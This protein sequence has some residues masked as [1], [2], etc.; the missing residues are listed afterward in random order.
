MF[1]FKIGVG[2]CERPKNPCCNANIKKFELDVD[3]ACRKAGFTSFYGKDLNNLVK[4]P[5]QPFFDNPDGA[6]PDGLVLKVT[7]LGLNKS[8]ADGMHLCFQYIPSARTPARCGTPAGLCRG[9]D[10]TGSRLCNVALTS[11]DNNCCPVT[12]FIPAAPPSPPRP[13][14]ATP[15]TCTVCV[16]QAINVTLGAAVA[17][18]AGAVSKITADVCAY[19]RDGVDYY[20]LQDS[21]DPS[22]ACISNYNAAKAELNVGMK[23]CFLTTAAVAED[24][25]AS[26]YDSKGSLEWLVELIPDEAVCARVDARVTGCTSWPDVKPYDGGCAFTPE[27]PPPE[28]VTPTTIAP[29]PMP[30]RTFGAAALPAYSSWRYPRWFQIIIGPLDAEDGENCLSFNATATTATKMQVS[31]CNCRDPGQLV[32][33]SFGKSPYEDTKVGPLGFAVIQFT[34]AVDV[35]RTGATPGGC[36]QQPLGLTISEVRNDETDDLVLGPCVAPPQSNQGRRLQGGRVGRAAGMGGMGDGTAGGAVKAAWGAEDA[37]VELNGGAK[38]T[39]YLTYGDPALG[40]LRRTGLRRLTQAGGAGS[41]PALIFISKN[42]FT[43]PKYRVIMDSRGLLP[44]TIRACL[45]AVMPPEAG[46]ELVFQRCKYAPRPGFPA[47]R[48]FLAENQKWRLVRD[49]DARDAARSLLPV[50]STDTPFPYFTIKSS[51]TDSGGRELCPSPFNANQGSPSKVTTERGLCIYS[52]GAVGQP[53][54]LISSTTLDDVGKSV[55]C[56]PLTRDLLLRIYLAVDVTIKPGPD[57][58]NPD[59]IPVPDAIKKSVD[60]Y[61]KYVW[62]HLPQIIPSKT[63]ITNATRYIPSDPNVTLTLYGT[64]FPVLVVDGQ[65]LISGM[66]RVVLATNFVKSTAFNT[67]EDTAFCDIRPGRY[68]VLASPEMVIPPNGSWARWTKPSSEPSLGKPDDLFSQVVLDLARWITQGSSKWDEDL[69]QRGKLCTSNSTYQPFLEFLAAERPDLFEDVNSTSIQPL[70]SLATND[71]QAADNLIKSCDVYVV[72]HFDNMYSL[73]SPSLALNRYLTAGGKALLAV[74]NTLPADLSTNTSQIRIFESGIIVDRITEPPADFGIGGRRRA[75]ADPDNKCLDALF[76]PP[77]PPSPPPS[78]P[79]PPSPPVPGNSSLVVPKGA[80]TKKVTDDLDARFSNIDSFAA[81]ILDSSSTPPTDPDAQLDLMFKQQVLINSL[82]SIR[83]ACDKDAKTNPSDQNLRN[84]LDRVNQLLTSMK[85]YRDELQL[86]SEAVDL[87][88]DDRLTACSAVVFQESSKTVKQI[89]YLGNLL[90]ATNS[91]VTIVDWHVDAPNRPSAAVFMDSSVTIS[92]SFWQSIGSEFYDGDGGQAP[93]LIQANRTSITLQN[94]SFANYTS[95]PVSGFRVQL[96]ANN[97]SGNA[98]SDRNADARGGAVY[99]DSCEPGP[100]G[101][102]IEGGVLQYN[103]ARMGGALYIFEC[104]ATLLGVPVSGNT[105][106]YGGAVYAQHAGSTPHLTQLRMIDSRFE[107]NSAS[108]QGGALFTLATGVLV[109]NCTFVRQSAIYSAVGVVKEAS[110]DVIPQ[111]VPNYD[112]SWLDGPAFMRLTVTNSTFADN[113][114]V[115]S[116]GVLT[117]DDSESLFIGYGGVLMLTSCRVTGANVIS[118]AFGSNYAHGSGGAIMGSA[119]KML[120]QNSTFDRNIAVAHGGAVYSVHR[121]SAASTEAA[122]PPLR[123]VESV[124]TANSAQQ[125]DGGAVLALS[126]RVNITTCRFEDNAAPLGRGGGCAVDNNLHLIT[127]GGTFARNR[128]SEGGALMV[129][130]T[131]N[132]TISNLSLDANTASALGGGASITLCPCVDV[133][134]ATATNNTAGTGVTGSGGGIHLLQTTKLRADSPA[135]CHLPP[136]HSAWFVSVAA[137]GNT[138]AD[139]GGAFLIDGFG[140]DVLLTNMTVSGNTAASGWGGGIAIMPPRAGEKGLVVGT[141]YSNQVVIGSSDLSSNLAGSGGGAVAVLSADVA[142]SMQLLGSVLHNNRAAGDG[143]AVHV[144]GN[145]TATISQ[146]VLSGNVAQQGSGGALKALGC[147]L[148]DITNSTFAANAATELGGAAHVDACRMLSLQQIWVA[149]NTAASAGGLAITNPTTDS[150]T[151]ALVL[152]STFYGDVAASN[153]STAMG[154]GGAMVIRGRVAALVTDTRFDSNYADTQGGAVLVDSTACQGVGLLPHPVVGNVSCNTVITSANEALDDLVFNN[155]ARANGGAFYVTNANGLLIACDAEPPQ[156]SDVN[157]TVTRSTPSS[158]A[159][160]FTSAVRADAPD[161]LKSARQNNSVKAFVDLAT[162]TT[163]SNVSTGYGAFVASTP[164]RLSLTIASWTLV[165][166]TGNDTTGGGAQN[167]TVS[168]VTAGADGQNSTAG[169][170]LPAAPPAAGGGDLLAQKS[171]TLDTAPVVSSSQDGAVKVTAFSNRPMDLTFYLY[172]AFDQVAQDGR[173][174]YRMGVVKIREDATVNYSTSSTSA[175]EPELKGSLAGIVTRGN[176][177]INAFRVRAPKGSY[178]LNITV[179]DMEFDANSVPPLQVEVSIPPCRVGETP[180]S[181]DALCD[182]CRSLTFSLWQDDAPLNGS[183]RRTNTDN[184]RCF[185]CPDRAKCPGGAVM[186]PEQGSWH[187]AANSTFFIECPNKGACRDGDDYL[188]RRLQPCQEWWYQQGLDFDYQAF[189]DSIL[190]GDLSLY[191]DAPRAVNGTYDPDA[192]CAL[193]GLPQGHPAAYMTRQCSESYAGNVCGTCVSVDGVMYS[194]D[195]AFN[196]TECM[197]KAATIVLL[198]VFFLISTFNIFYATL[199][200]FM[201]DYT[202]E[203]ESEMAVGDIIQV[204]IQHFQYYNIITGYGIDWPASIQ[205]LNTAFGMLTGNVQQQ[206]ATPSCLLSPDAS[207][208]QQAEAEQYTALFSPAI[209]LG[210]VLFLWCIRSLVWNARSVYGAATELDLRRLSQLPRPAPE[211]GTTE[212][213]EK[214]N[215]GGKGESAGDQDGLDDANG[216]DGGDTK[217]GGGG[218]GDGEDAAPPP[219]PPTCCGGLTALVC[220]PIKTYMKN[221]YSMEGEEGQARWASLINIDR[222]TGIFKQFMIVTLVV[223]GILYPAWAQATLSIFSCYFLDT[224]EGEW[225]EYQLATAGSGYWVRDMNQACYTGYH[226]STWLPLGIAFIAIVCVGV[227]FLSAFVL[228]LN[229][230]RL[231]TVHVAQTYG[232]LYRRYT[233]ERYLWGAVSQIQMLLSVVVDVFGTVLPPYMQAVLFQISLIFKM[234]IDS[235]FMPNKYPLLARLEFLS[236]A[237]LS[238]T[239]SLGLFFL[240]PAG[241]KDPVT[242]AAEQGI[243]AIILVLNIGICLYLMVRPCYTCRGTC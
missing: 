180:S 27:A 183:C 141:N 68:S 230:N 156:S 142:V 69:P 33:F 94:C 26:W 232:F 56:S 197:A 208:Q 4:T 82:T 234:S 214:G 115:D 189:A 96:L 39:T 123:I 32:K 86:L 223:T 12:D 51:L 129:T 171:S 59:I 107:A 124:F 206:A 147:E 195:G 201:A 74:V 215:N 179:E 114:A 84:Q 243:A 62:Q 122:L 127:T 238:I 40:G 45:T 140:D 170:T 24:A 41:G 43:Q 55:Q 188:Q 178:K 172:D 54:R 61:N 34:A 193:W 119:C 174:G 225:P 42:F 64:A 159:D 50:G 23:L 85:K 177:T 38:R 113:A 2:A 29:P 143:G 242:P 105:G 98:M 241:Q 17:K 217:E 138:A 158:F 224:G 160:L 9:A 75:Q 200:T 58:D 137:Q 237:V 18:D 19:I 6:P 207:S 1:C 134:N 109:V 28:I 22:P 239:I 16:D 153:D 228:W 169:A 88:P 111:I 210:A 57:P 148:L 76:A 166:A 185:A 209:L 176:T 190:A 164:V 46:D 235:Y 118:S 136:R 104:N 102:Y 152:N 92:N 83:A 154:Y 165:Q 211:D 150:A 133:S 226:S 77:L 162:Q 99:A 227:P 10:S 106:E 213:V 108:L 35:N 130:K 175:C 157:G 78:P 199:F 167:S 196:C 72:D 67:S 229:R 216:G 101:L 145:V 181:D 48:G 135:V 44:S 212:D 125:G 132:V 20:P 7:E 87:G 91:I 203:E 163:D 186:F 236:L 49:R 80:T 89:P 110:K 192:A 149:G 21:A 220:L 205:G 222:T 11:S 161:C 25:K 37:G 5:T 219:A 90:N 81:T 146:V 66:S 97:F 103:Q 63:N 144:A 121:R 60:V 30:P 240:P 70:S 31:P 194:N 182:K 173:E 187:S 13:P 79:R 52:T 128:A 112:M 65:K 116:A 202:Q 184:A 14:P 191:P 218:T 93:P 36:V 47:N 120:V 151:A 100:T 117:V 53:P 204:A 221:T 95:T 126:I 73:A 8:N 3:P 131:D 168:D 15:T 71:P 155:T 198:I 231:Q 233:P 139:S